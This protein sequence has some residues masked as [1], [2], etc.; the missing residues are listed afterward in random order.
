MQSQA[1]CMTAASRY[2]EAAPLQAAALERARALNARRYEAVILAQS[3]EVAL[4]QGRR[5]EALEL[6]RAGQ[7][8]SEEAGPGFAGPIVLGLLGL[9]EESCEAKKAAL[10]AGEALLAKGAVGHN[11]F[12]FRRYAIEGALLAKDWSEVDRQADILLARMKAE[13]LA[14][15]TRIAERGRLLARRGRGEA[16]KADEEKLS[17]LLAEAAKD[18]MRIEAMGEALRAL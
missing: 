5:D 12:F 13:P 14:Y 2:G 3:A 1:L 10:A 16:S 7:K 18:D 8:V 9:M 17:R 4:C 11:H 6:A 15:S